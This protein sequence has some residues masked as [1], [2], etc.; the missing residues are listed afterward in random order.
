MLEKSIFMQATI[1]R[2]ESP[3]IFSVNFLIHQ[4]WK[5]PLCF[6]WLP[7]TLLHDSR[8]WLPGWC[9]KGIAFL[10]FFFLW[11]GY[12]IPSHQCNMHP[13]PPFLHPQRVRNCYAPPTT[14]HKGYCHTSP[15]TARIYFW[16]LAEDFVWAFYGV[17]PIV[18]QSTL[19]QRHTHLQRSTSTEIWHLQ[20]KRVIFH[21]SR[22]RNCTAESEECKKRGNNCLNTF[23]NFLNLRTAVVHRRSRQWALMFLIS[24]QVSFNRH[25]QTSFPH[26]WSGWGPVALSASKE[27]VP[28][29]SCPLPAWKCI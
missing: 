21:C 23:Q 7:S 6:S 16:Q 4:T 15:S 22:G 5:A 2:E 8:K 11:K 26:V 18:G 29:S 24:M 14:H 10:A 1:L 20:R 28:P 3:N 27:T 13:S 17:A 19:L 12:V 9:N 25:Q